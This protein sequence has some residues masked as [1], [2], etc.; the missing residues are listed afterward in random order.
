MKTNLFKYIGLTLN[1]YL[2]LGTLF[3]EFIIIY[4]YIDMYVLKI[5]MEDEMCHSVPYGLRSMTVPLLTVCVPR[6]YLLGTWPQS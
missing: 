1:Y 6:S 2:K 5:R 4:I 3:F